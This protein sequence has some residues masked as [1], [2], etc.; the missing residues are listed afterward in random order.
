VRF[1]HVSFDFTGQR[2]VV[3]GGSRG[4]GRGVV[5]GLVAAGATVAYGS[6]APAEPPIDGADHLPVEL[7]N[8]ASILDFF[9]QAAADGP[10]DLCV[11]AAAINH[12][13]RFEE[14]TADE[15]DDVHGVDLRAAFLVAREAGRRMKAQGSGHIVN[16]SS[17]A[18]RHRSPVSG[19][20]YVSAKAGMIGL[21]RQMAFELAPHGVT[22]NVHCPSQTRTEML[23]ATMSEGQQADL[24]AS[25]PLGRLAEVRDQVGPILF[26][27]SDAADYMTGAVLDV[28]GGQV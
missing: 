20:H 25:I 19:V 8:E 5:E 16:V 28:N 2:A 24:A 3:I 11:Y 18:G 13:R 9:E 1:G 7:R 27:C 22:V 23:E 14:I 21:T 4:I 10:L 26:L 6:R 17:I 15:W 12:A